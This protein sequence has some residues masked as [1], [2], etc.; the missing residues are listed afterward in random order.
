MSTT[1]PMELML[2]DSV[3]NELLKDAEID[4]RVGDHDAL[5]QKI[6]KDKWP[7]GDPRTKV[8]FVLLTAN[9]A[10]ADWT[11]SPPPPPEVVKAEKDSWEPGKLKAIAN[12]V[13]MLRQLIK[14]Y[15]VTIDADGYPD[16]SEGDRFKVKT[17]KTRREQDGS[18][19]FIRVIAFLAKDRPVGAEAAT[20]ATA[21]SRPDF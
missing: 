10:K 15:G 14:E 20:S 13:A 4:K 16:I 19:G 18:G 8:N 6:V 21:G 12:S 1:D 2:N 7:S 11:F 5:V 9:N 17:T 3:Y